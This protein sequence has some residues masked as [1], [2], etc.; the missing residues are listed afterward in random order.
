MVKPLT[1]ILKKNLVFTWT[2]EGKTSFDGIKQSIASAPTL[3]NPKFD[4]DFI[5]YSLG[6]KPSILVVLTQLND[7]NLEQPIAFFSDG[8]NDNGERYSYIEKQVLVVVRALKKFRHLLSHKKV[9]LLV[10]HASVKDFFLNMDINE[11]RDGQIT[12]VMEYDIDINITK[13]VRGKGLCEQ[14]DSSFETHEEVSLLIQTEKPMENKDKI[15]WLQDITTLLTK[16]IYPQGQTQPRGDS[17][18]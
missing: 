11:K 17:L 15:D 5:L 16:G 7:E 1:T 18:D 10:P 2:K 13:L 6:G 9:Q 14:M 4:R 8:L 12:K 3:V